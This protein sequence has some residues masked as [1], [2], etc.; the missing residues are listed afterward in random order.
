M[1]TLRLLTL[2]FVLAGLLLA[3]G[4]EVEA[5]RAGTYRYVIPGDS[6][7]S[8]SCARQDPC[9]L[10]YA[11]YMANPGDIIIVHSGTYKSTDMSI[12]LVFIDKSL[13]LLGSCTFDAST[14]HECHPDLRNSILDAEN[15]KR[16]IRLE[17][18][19]GDEQVHLEG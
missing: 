17:G 15:T 13:T 5:E 10:N 18:V 11:V 6:L 4:S 19:S 2:T 12:D 1:K 3:P 8:T 16:V 7:T 14:S 9:D